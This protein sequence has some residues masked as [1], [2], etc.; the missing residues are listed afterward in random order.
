MEDLDVV[1]GH[2]LPKTDVAIVKNVNQHDFTG[3]TVGFSNVKNYEENAYKMTNSL[4]VFHALEIVEN[5]KFSCNFLV[6]AFHKLR[7]F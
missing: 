6:L 1:H 7:K 3:C 2:T 4:T 5:L